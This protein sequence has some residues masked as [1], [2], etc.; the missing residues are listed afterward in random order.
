MHGL[1][2]SQTT[3]KLKVNVGAEINEIGEWVGSQE[4]V[5]RLDG[6]LDLLSGSSAYD[7][8]GTKFE[9]STHIFVAD[10]KDLPSQFITHNATLEVQGIDYD[11]TLIDN[12]MGM[13]QQWEIYLRYRGPCSNGGA[14]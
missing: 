5:A 7:L 3:A 9:D 1:I 2:G 13:N 4:I 8:M 12:P 6:W 11:V 14:A 10:Y